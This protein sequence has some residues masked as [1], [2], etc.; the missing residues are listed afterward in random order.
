[1]TESLLKKIIIHFKCHSIKVQTINSTINENFNRKKL[2][3]SW[4][5]E[6]AFYMNSS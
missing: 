3:G 2:F 1:M 4:W 5:T 6:T